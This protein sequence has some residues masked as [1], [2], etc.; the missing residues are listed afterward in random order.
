[1]DGAKN[2]MHALKKSAGEMQYKDHGIAE[3]VNYVIDR[4]A[5]G[6]AQRCPSVG[7]ET[8][9]PSSIKLSVNSTW[10]VAKTTSN[11]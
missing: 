7:A 1:M 9:R 4:Q 5:E 11:R 10:M 6:E 3:D 2:F 8:S